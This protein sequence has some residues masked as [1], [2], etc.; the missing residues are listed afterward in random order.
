MKS[1]KSYLTLTVTDQGFIILR[2]ETCI[3][4]CAVWPAKFT[5]FFTFLQTGQF[6]HEDFEVIK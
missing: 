4:S 1:I 3:K 5:F 2:H 6:G